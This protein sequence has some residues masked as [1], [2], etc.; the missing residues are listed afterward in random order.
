MQ[1][2]KGMPEEASLTPCLLATFGLG[3]RRHLSVM[4]S[5][6][7]WGMQAESALYQR[8]HKRD[9]WVAWKDGFLMSYALIPAVNKAVKTLLHSE[10]SPSQVQFVLFLSFPS[11]D[12]RMA[13]RL[14]PGASHPEAPN[15]AGK[16]L[17]PSWSPMLPLHS[18]ND[19]SQSAHLIISHLC[20]RPIGLP[21]ACRESPSSISWHPG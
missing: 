8:W 4:S 14:S 1:S 13:P 17:A 11:V 7:L 18:P 12:G 6:T 3:G 16:E 19:L 20:S 21:M 5:P 2:I 15:H 10:A 9:S